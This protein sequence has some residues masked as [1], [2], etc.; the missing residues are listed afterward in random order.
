MARKKQPQQPQPKSSA[1]PMDLSSDSSNE[2]E[3]ENAEDS[4]GAEQPHIPASVVSVRATWKH[5]RSTLSLLLRGVEGK[6]QLLIARAVRRVHAL[7]KCVTVHHLR[8]LVAQYCGP[9]FDGVVAKAEDVLRQ[10]GRND[11]GSSER[12]QQQ[13]QQQQRHH[14]VGDSDAD[15]GVD[16]DSEE[17]MG[18]ALP[19][20]QKDESLE[21]AAAK[22]LPEVRAYIVLLGLLFALDRGAYQQVAQTTA[23]LVAQLPEDFN[24]R[25]LDH[26]TARIY[27][28]YALS[29]ELTGRSLET[30]SVLLRAHRTACLRHDE[31]GQ[32]VLT[33]AILR[34]FLQFNLVSQADKFRLNVTLPDN[35]SSDQ[36]ARFLYYL[37]R[38]N[39]VQLHYSE[40]F[41]N[42]SQA[43]RKANVKAVGFSQAAHKLLIIV[44][45]LM[46]EIPE[47][48]IFALPHLERS[49]KPYLRIAKVRFHDDSYNN[50]HH[51]QQ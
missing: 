38:I 27:Y 42:L 47:R 44:Q 3:K 22:V 51:Q 28:Y 24:R 19:K 14:L 5:L 30:R 12:K 37:G 50:H 10:G 35:V 31:P 9:D 49:L 23:Q 32:A 17:V 18:V 40:A 48:S 34:H 6:D 45:L 8:F 26:I 13:Q 43:I 39:S 20:V 25:T 7:R 15:A 41:D 16:V 36:Q 11:S 21:D 2:S 33:N 1:A 29:H 4:N 46:G